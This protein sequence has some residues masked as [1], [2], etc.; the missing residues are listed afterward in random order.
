MPASGKMLGST[1]RCIGIWERTVYAIKKLFKIKREL[2]L[3]SFESCLTPK[4]LLKLLK[5]LLILLN[6]DES[7]NH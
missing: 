2:G 1:V 4:K 6:P 3:F 5:T 7:L